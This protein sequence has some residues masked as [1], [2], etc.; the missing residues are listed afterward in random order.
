M[1]FSLSALRLAAAR[2]MRG[3]IARLSPT[4]VATAIDTAAA[5]GFRS[6]LPAYL[7]VQATV[8]EQAG[9]A[10]ALATIRQRIELVSQSPPGGR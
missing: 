8:A 4:G 9:D 3:R 5:Q 7:N 10:A 6:P 1:T 2:R